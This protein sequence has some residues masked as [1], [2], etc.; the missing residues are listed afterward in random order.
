MEEVLDVDTVISSLWSFLEHKQ[1]KHEPILS[2]NTI[3]AL[4]IEARK[5]LFGQPVLLELFSP[6]RVLGELK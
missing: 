3:K 6:I 4:L 5:V 2:E 1:R